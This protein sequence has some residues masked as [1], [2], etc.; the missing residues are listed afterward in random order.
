MFLPFSSLSLSYG[1]GL[2]D[3]IAGI[4]VGMVLVPQSMSYAKLAGL[5]PEFGLYSSFIGQLH[6]FK[7]IPFL[8][9]QS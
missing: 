2:V 9:A 1:F 3:L 5:R 7:S 8:C 4:T 6:S